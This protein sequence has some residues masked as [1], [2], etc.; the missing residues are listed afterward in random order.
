MPGKHTASAHRRS[1]AL[2]ASDARNH[3][4]P[5]DPDR[6]PGHRKKTACGAAT[7]RT[8]S[9]LP[10]SVSDE[11]PT[12]PALADDNALERATAILAETPLRRVRR[13]EKEI[14]AERDRIRQA[15]SALEAIYG[16]PA[17][18]DDGF[19]NLS[20]E[21][22][23]ELVLAEAEKR[24]EKLDQ[25]LR[26]ER[27]IAAQQQLESGRL[28]RLAVAARESHPERRKAT[29]LLRVRVTWAATATLA[30]GLSM[31]TAQVVP[32]SATTA[33]TRMIIG[34]GVSLAFAALHNVSLMVGHGA[35]EAMNAL[36]AKKPWLRKFADPVTWFNGFLRVLPMFNVLLQLAFAFWAAANLY[37]VLSQVVTEN[38]R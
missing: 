28:Q 27:L 14:L 34:A 19:D 7:S 25:A 30:A 33:F 37:A 16:G 20:P 17:E 4:G 13:L 5:C 31:A 18:N 29:D 26:D 15:Q 24:I 9:Y 32:A 11:E 1:S 36:A 3:P 8:S 38:P 22:Q 6:Q 12:K 10:P 21:E 2:L 35:I 23:A